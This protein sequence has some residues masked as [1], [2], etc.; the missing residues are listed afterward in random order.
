MPIVA[1]IGKFI[2]REYAYRV[3]ITRYLYN[4]ACE[5]IDTERYL[6]RQGKSTEDTMR[7]L[8]HQRRNL[9][10]EHIIA[11]K[12]YRYITQIPGVCLW[13]KSKNALQR[14]LPRKRVVLQHTLFFDKW[15][16]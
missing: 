15:L 7:Q 10:R 1:W 2:W 9:L 14:L 13:D 12:K 6:L 5:I 8:I 3:S 4:T 16:V 11:K